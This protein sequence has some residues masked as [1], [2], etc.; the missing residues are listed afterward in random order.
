MHLSMKLLKEY[1]AL[2][3]TYDQRWSAYLH[4]SLRMTFEKITDQPT[5]RLL[6]VACGTG[7]ILD[8]P[9]E[10]SDCSELVGIDKVPAMLAVA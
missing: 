2:A 7:L 5:G 1:T 9:S 6:D 3:P 8:M 4:A 10:R